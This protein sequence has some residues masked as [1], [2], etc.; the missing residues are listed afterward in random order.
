ARD[1][2]RRFVAD[3]SHEL[4]TPLTALRGNVAYLARHGADRDVVSDL[5][6]DAAR[7]ARLIDDLLVLSREDAGE[8]PLEEVRLDEAVGAAAVRGRARVRALLARGARKARFRTRARDCARDGRTP[9]RP[10]YGGRRTLHDRAPRS[11]GS[12]RVD[13]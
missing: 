5:E 4:R 12:L 9:R 6:A 2:E 10:R 11:Q 7:L 1:A 3:A 8:P 13:R